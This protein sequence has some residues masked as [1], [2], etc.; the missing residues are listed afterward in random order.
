MARFAPGRFRNPALAWPKAGPLAPTVIR[1]FF[2]VVAGL[3][4]LLL[5]AAE[6]PAPGLT[7][8]GA[9]DTSVD[10]ASGESTMR[11]RVRISDAGLLFEADLV[12][13][14]RTTD[15]VTASGN[16]VLTIVPAQVA[17]GDVRADS[18]GA[19]L[20]AERL[21]YNRRTQS[22]T[23]E[24]IRF[25]S[26]PV[27]VEGRS[28]SGSRQ[29]VTIEQ[30]RGIFGEPNR[31]Q[32]TF[33][34]NRLIYEP[35]RQIQT[36]GALLGIGEVRP[37]SLARFEQ[38]LTQPFAFTVS[39]NGGYRSALG[40]FAEGNVQLPVSRALRLGGTVGL[41]TKRGV[42]A[43]PS[44]RYS[45]PANPEGL[46]GYFRSGYISDYGDR[47][48]DILGRPVPRDRAYAEWQHTQRIGDA[49]TLQA[50]LNWWKDSEVLRD[51]RPKEFYPVQAPDTFV[52]S[53]YTGPNFFA[54]VFGRFQ[55]NSF[56]RVQER[57]PEFRFDLLP[58]ALPGGFYERF[59]GSVAVLREDPILT[60]STLESRR[61]D[62]YYALS[63]PIQPS[64]WSSIT[65]VAA[66]RFTHYTSTVGALRDGNYTR[67][68]GE[69]G[70]DAELRASGV[71]AYANPRWKIDGLR[72]LITPRVG[73]R[74]I[75]EADRGQAHIPR[76]DR[77]VFSTYL[78]PIGLGQARNI[79]ELHGSHVVRLGF[80]NTV[81]TRD[82]VH[83]S[84]DLLLFNL[85]NDFRLQRRPG[86]KDVSDLHADVSLMPA[87]WLQLDAYQSLSPQN[88]TLREFNSGVTVHDGNAWSLRFAN[89]YLRR[90]LEDYLIDGRVRLN[91]S[92][93]TL[94]RVHYDARRR[95]LNEQSYGIIHNLANTWLI[96]YTV[97]LY[98]G[99][100][101]ESG[102]GFNVQID[103]VRF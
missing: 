22:F 26:Y 102:F 74:Y 71:F 8:S 83:G 78:P 91:E 21:V 50:Q 62:G 97:S 84:R 63:R 32:P 16:V 79:D 39:M 28:A 43:G 11:G 18:G 48:T 3:A 90:E 12:R 95:R 52:E 44:G 15:I 20:L 47:E 103:T 6:V 73:Y 64:N 24:N 34:A 92:F 4:A 81:Q 94:V 1:R 100:R 45:D 25:G 5:R 41:Y 36:E 49:L 27:F 10:L 85:A 31:W 54:S 14:N 35:G 55:P 68:L 98:S 60:G 99:R 53:V 2:I 19:R 89:N 67:V 56:Q 51:F 86:E 42:M 13:H 33:Y 59:N 69:L 23:A 76:I 61:L 17:P 37:I 87:S 82:P 57:R 93:E 77:T 7:I 70:V 65:P 66:A 46:H 80:D 38:D 75:P 30:A 29:R 88:F 72:H 96:S 101:R 9:D 58:V 40:A